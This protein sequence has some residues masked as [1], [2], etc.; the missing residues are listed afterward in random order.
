[1]LRNYKGR[2]RRCRKLTRAG[3]NVTKS[4]SNGGKAATT[5]GQAVMEVVSGMLRDQRRVVA[6][7]SAPAAGTCGQNVDIAL[8]IAD[9]GPSG[10]VGRAFD[11][12]ERPIG[13][14]PKLF[15]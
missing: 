15:G 4:I 11:A 2:M 8:V 13:Q 7:V 9:G 14:R 3:T 10:R 6:A 5:Y 12:H 1:M